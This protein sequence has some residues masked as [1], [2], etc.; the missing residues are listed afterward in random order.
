MADELADRRGSSGRDRKRQVVYR[1]D[2]E[3]ASRIYVFDAE[4]DRFLAVAEPREVVHPL[5]EAGS[6]DEDR[7]SAQMALRRGLEKQS[8]K[9]LKTLRQ[10][11][12]NALLI[13]SREA[14]EALG[15]RD[16]YEPEAPTPI[17]K[18][19]DS[20]T[21]RA[22]KAGADHA[23]ARRRTAEAERQQTESISAREWLLTG[24][25]HHH[26]PAADTGDVWDDLTKEPD[27]DDTTQST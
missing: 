16:D 13:S 9:H 11:S 3:D 19:T 25:D 21:G 5:A 22:A 24:T 20:E 15:K 14:A 26:A 10:S 12:R 2:P 6:E 8:R 17:L 4:S 1:Y 27:D 18:I 7:V 23:E